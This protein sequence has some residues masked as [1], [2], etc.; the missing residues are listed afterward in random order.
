MLI[1]LFNQEGVLVAWMLP[2]QHLFN[3]NMDWIAYIVKQNVWSAATNRWLGPLRA[4]TCLDHQGRVVAWNPANA[5]RGIPQPLQ[6]VGPKR[7][8]APLRPV[9]PKNPV[10]PRRPGTIKGGWSPLSL[11]EW[12][13][14]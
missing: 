4:T 3:L 10:A 11:R 1:P 14:Q 7:P 5:P 12:L 9:R 6:G 2:D 8:P 13:D